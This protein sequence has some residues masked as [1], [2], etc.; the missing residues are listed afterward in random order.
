MAQRN[1]E[2]SETN[3]IS[4]RTILRSSA[5]LAAVG[6]AGTAP[7]GAQSGEGLP[8]SIEIFAEDE[9]ITITNDGEEDVDLTGYSINFEAPEDDYDQI[10]ALSGEVVLSPGN[11][12]TVPTGTTSEVS[13][14]TIV[15]LQDPYETEV[16]N[17]EEP[18]D[19]AILDEQGNVVASSGDTG[20]GGDDGE[21]D[22]EGDQQGDDDGGQADDGS[23]DDEAEEPDE[24]DED[25]QT[26]GTT[27]E[28]A[29]S[30][31]TDDDC[32]KR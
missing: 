27:G 15:E 25:E 30:D 10:R 3:S 29:G 8:L 19:V 21:T 23:T 26:E 17:N 13:T 9:Y 14:G 7:T 31:E 1:S 18:D 2:K 11:T 12:I 32:P 24:D 6:V 20:D 4:R 5:V 22:T 16:L 28:G